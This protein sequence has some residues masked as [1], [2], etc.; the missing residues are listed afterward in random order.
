MIYP[1]EAVIDEATPEVS[2]TGAVVLSLEQ[3]VT[4]AIIAAEA[5][6]EI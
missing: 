2:A 6:T 5:A 3:P 1:F 4:A